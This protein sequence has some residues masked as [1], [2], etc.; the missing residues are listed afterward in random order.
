MKA[1]S[2]SIRMFL[3]AA[4]VKNKLYVFFLQRLRSGYYRKCL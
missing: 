2:E 1:V 3:F 4:P